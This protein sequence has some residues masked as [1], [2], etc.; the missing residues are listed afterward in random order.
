MYWCK[1]QTVFF[2]LN[3][4][5]AHWGM[6]GRVRI[7]TF[8]PV[9]TA[10]E[11]PDSHFPSLAL[12]VL[13]CK[14]G[15]YQTSLLAVLRAR[16][17]IR[18][19]EAKRSPS[20]LTGLPSPAVTFYL[21]ILRLITLYIFALSLTRKCILKYSGHA[22]RVKDEGNTCPCIYTFSWRNS[23]RPVC[24]CP[25]VP[26]DHI[27]LLLLCPLGVATVVNLAFRITIYLKKSF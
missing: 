2:P 18:G 17:E 22:R 6:W 5:L 15:L 13:G 11:T 27:L 3:A 23:I 8:S 14:V 24:Q 1:H 7:A 4:V 19:Y 20:S 26:S 25:C 21:N 16:D 12:T 10:H 9:L